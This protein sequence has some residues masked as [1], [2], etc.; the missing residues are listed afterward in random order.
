MYIWSKPP[1][2]PPVSFAL[3]QPFSDEPPRRAGN[4][5]L[6]LSSHSAV[7]GLA[8]VFLSAAYR[9]LCQVRDRGRPPLPPSPPPE[10]LLGHY[11]TVPE[12]AAFKWYDERAK[13]YSMALERQSHHH[14]RGANN[15]IPLT[16]PTESDVLFFQ[17]FGTKWIVLNSLQ[18]ATELL[19]R[20]G[21]NYADRPRFVMFEE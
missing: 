3:T 15:W 16:T 18:S 4:M 21:S 13:E 20:R 19:E 2:P 17:T 7:L 6:V 14:R 5:D 11:R 8:V 1:P 12:D 9:I 10:F